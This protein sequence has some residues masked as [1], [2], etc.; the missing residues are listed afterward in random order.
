MKT[1]IEELRGFRRVQN[2]TWVFVWGEPVLTKKAPLS[3]QTIWS[4]W[5]EY[6]SDSFYID[7][8]IDNDI[9]PNEICVAWNAYC[10]FLQCQSAR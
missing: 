1:R 9:Y 10:K 8:P 5:H 7:W 6:I 4:A 2:K 3:N